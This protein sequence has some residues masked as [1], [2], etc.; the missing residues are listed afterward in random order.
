VDF[1]KIIGRRQFLAKSLAGIT[2][3]GFLGLS[4]QKPTFKTQDQSNR[5]KKDIIYRVRAAYRMNLKKIK[6]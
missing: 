4:I 6:I 3:A 1:N 2:S 5:K